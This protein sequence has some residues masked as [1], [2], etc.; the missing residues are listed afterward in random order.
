MVH[1]LVASLGS[2][3]LGAGLGSP[4]RSREDL[5]LHRSQGAEREGSKVWVLAGWVHGGIEGC[6]DGRLKDGGMSVWK[7]RK[8]EE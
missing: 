5:D 8:M 3:T 1:V 7:S 4:C 6:K 2:Q